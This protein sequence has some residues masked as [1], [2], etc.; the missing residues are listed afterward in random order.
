MQIQSY[1]IHILTLHLQYPLLEN[2]DLTDVLIVIPNTLFEN[3]VLL[4]LIAKMHM[5]LS[6][7]LTSLLGIKI[8]VKNKG[9]SLVINITSMKL[10]FESAL[11]MISELLLE[12]PTDKPIL[13]ALLAVNS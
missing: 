12:F 10:T 1:S 5:I 7:F 4:M 3:S 6:Q 11:N 2:T 9:F 13:E 8:F